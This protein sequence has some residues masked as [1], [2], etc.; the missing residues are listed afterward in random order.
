MWISITFMSSLSFSASAFRLCPISGRFLFSSLPFPLLP[1]SLSSIHSVSSF[2]S[3]I[4]FCVDESRSSGTR[5]AFRSPPPFSPILV[6]V[7]IC[8][9]FCFYFCSSITFPSPFTPQSTNHPID[10]SAE[11]IINVFSLRAWASLSS[12]PC[13]SVPLLS[14]FLTSFA[15]APYPLSSLLIP[16]LLLLFPIIFLQILVMI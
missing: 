3:F 13:L 11:F 7:S 6:C 8:F 12:H 10:V 9:C 5:S 15:F 14:F 4:S 2:G 16:H 1:S